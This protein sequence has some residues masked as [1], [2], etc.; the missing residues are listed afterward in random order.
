M[1][2]GITD[3]IPEEARGNTVEGLAADRNRPWLSPRQARKWG[4]DVDNW[5]GRLLRN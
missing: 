2:E 1:K 5:E 3:E 4:A